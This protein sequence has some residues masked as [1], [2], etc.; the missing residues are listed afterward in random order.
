MPKRFAKK[1]KPETH[2]KLE[3]FDI[4]INQFGQLI[5]TLTID[6]LNTFLNEEVPDKKAIQKP[7]K[8][9]VDRVDEEE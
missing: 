2:Q 5:S 9:E 1:G 8:P 6:Q 7:I 4:K 3:G